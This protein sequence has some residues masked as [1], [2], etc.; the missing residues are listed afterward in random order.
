MFIFVIND[1]IGIANIYILILFLG[2]YLF[3][4]LLGLVLEIPVH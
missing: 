4:Y 2:M 3:G 1:A